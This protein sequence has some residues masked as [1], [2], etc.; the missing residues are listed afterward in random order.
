MDSTLSAHATPT[1]SLP[2]GSLIPPPPP[3]QAP[4]A[5]RAS[6]VPALHE[7]LAS[8]TLPTLP[9]ATA[10]N[11][12]APE[13][14][15]G[16]GCPIFAMPSD[17]LHAIVIELRKADSTLHGIREVERLRATCGQLRDMIPRPIPEDLLGAVEFN[18]MAALKRLLAAP[19]HASADLAQALQQMGQLVRYSHPELGTVEFSPLLAAIKLEHVEMVKLLVEAGDLHELPVGWKEE[20]LLF[21]VDSNANDAAAVLVAAG[22]MVNHMGPD[23][24]P[25]LASAVGR[26]NAAMVRLLTQAG[27]EAD[28]VFAFTITSLALAAKL[29]KAE[30]IPALLDGGAAVDR[31]AKDGRTALLDAR[32]LGHEAAA[33]ALRSGGAND[34]PAFARAAQ[35]PLIKGFIRLHAGLPMLMLAAVAGDTHLVEDLLSNGAAVNDFICLEDEPISALFLAA[36]YGHATVI[37]ILLEAGAALTAPGEQGES[38]LHYAVASNNAEVVRLLLQAGVAIDR[39]D[40]RDRTALA[41]AAMHGHHNVAACLLQAGAAVDAIA[42]FETRTALMLAAAHG[43]LAIVETLMQHGADVNRDDRDRQTSLIF[44]AKEGYVSTAKALLQGGANRG[45]KDRNGMTALDHAVKEGHHE[46]ADLLRAW[47]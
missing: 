8:D 27:A 5:A 6:R 22:A 7:R 15:P 41:N 25:V 33:E 42:Y 9:A 46:M 34:F 37:S 44:A 26:G 38:V 47:Q 21:A 45:H 13:M 14:L 18:D 23:G 31:R 16:D 29:G 3:A 40:P 24:V 17:V 10:S 39:V 12:S 19:G 30:V 4:D 1:S 28:K 36:M 11:G 32:I 35:M 20:A 2:L 43:H